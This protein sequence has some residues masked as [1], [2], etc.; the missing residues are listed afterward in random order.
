MKIITKNWT[1]LVLIISSF[2]IL[3]ALIA[4]NIFGYLPCK[5]CL[6]QRYPYYMIIIISAFFLLLR[7]ENNMVLLLI[8]EILLL[9]GLFFALWHVGIENQILIGPSG[10]SN[11]IKNAE[12]VN[13][14]RTIITNRPIVF[15]DEVNWSFL[16]ISFAIYNSL[17]LFALLIFNSIFLFKKND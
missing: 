12:S 2:A 8:I 17:L 9:I 1:I 5:M 16:G 6:Y 11:I 4:E 10:C 14:L 7:N 15:C 3:V 13:E